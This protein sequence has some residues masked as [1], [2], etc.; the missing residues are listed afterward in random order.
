MYCKSKASNC[1]VGS[2]L[3]G[4]FRSGHRFPDEGDFV[5]SWLGLTRGVCTTPQYFETVEVVLD[6]NNLYWDGWGEPMV[7]PVKSRNI[8]TKLPRVSS[9]FLR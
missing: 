2:N 1:F 4:H 9:G 5:G 8:I 6:L 3:Y 7:L